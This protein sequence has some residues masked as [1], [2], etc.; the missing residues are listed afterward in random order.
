MIA[1]IRIDTDETKITRYNKAGNATQSIQ[2]DKDGEALYTLPRCITENNNGDVVVSDSIDRSHGA[3]VV[4][5]RYGR[6]RFSYTGHLKGS[7]L[8]PLGICTD[9]FS[10]ILVC[11]FNSGSVHV[12]E[13]NGTFRVT[14]IHMYDQLGR[15]L[16]PMSLSY[17]VN[18]HLLWVGSFRKNVVYAS[19]YIH[20]HPH[21]TGTF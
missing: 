4:T 16:R 18:T 10:N 5:D 13:E 11:D 19:R 17:D 20:R 1:K 7:E 14:W 12:I 3:V 15:T 9:A 21:L 8:L 6:H 2:N